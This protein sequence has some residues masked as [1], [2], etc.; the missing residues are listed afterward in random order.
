M[1]AWA[2]AAVMAL[3]L[4]ES[5][6]AI[7]LRWL[8]LVGVAGAVVL[9]PPVAFGNWRV[10]PW[11]LLALALLPIL[12]RATVGGS[13]GNVATYIS[14]AA[15]ALLVVVELHMFTALSVTHWFAVA[16]VAMTTLAAVA[17]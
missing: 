4:I 1:L 15:L 2:M 8:L 9:L 5:F 16:L 7:D 3:V 6:L 17:V 10:V 14:L 13:L 12:V 11:D